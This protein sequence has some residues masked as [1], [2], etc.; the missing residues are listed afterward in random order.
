MLYLH[1]DIFLTDIIGSGH[2][3]LD[4][5]PAPY[6]SKGHSPHF[7][8]KL[9]YIYA[10]KNEILGTALVFATVSVRLKTAFCIH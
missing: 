4:G 1:N 7:W 6:H 3:V 8:L 10:L 5:D 2:I 9:G